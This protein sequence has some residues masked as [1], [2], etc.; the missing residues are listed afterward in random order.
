VRRLR[1]RG[2][3]RKEWRYVGAFSDELFVVAARVKV[4]PIGQTFWAVI[5]RSTG[6]MR[7]RTRLR[8]PGA[9]GDVWTE[10]GDELVTRIE[11]PGVSASLRIDPAEGRWAEAECPTESGSSVWTRKRV[12]PPIEVEIDLD[13]TRLQTTARGVED[14]SAGYHPNPTEW[15]WSAGIGTAPDGRAVG[16]NLVSGVNDPPTGSERAIWIEGE[17]Y[18]PGPVHFE[19]DLGRIAFGGGSEL[20]F[21]AEAE[22][23][24]RQNLGLVAYDYRQPF[25]TFGG[26]LDGIPLTSGI[27]VMEY[28]FARW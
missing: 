1:H 2:A 28:H 25:G 21:E 14:E 19:P 17:P 7:E 22:R 10:S 16:W 20:T 27:G 9:R 4:G 3:W 12:G 8:L 15:F 23:K 11:A 5:D 24:S 13:G 6:E 26:T 18:E